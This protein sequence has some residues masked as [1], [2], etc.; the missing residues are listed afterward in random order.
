MY[1][2]YQCTNKALGSVITTFLLVHHRGTPPYIVVY[3]N[4]LVHLSTHYGTPLVHHYVYHK[5]MALGGMVTV[6]LCLKK[7]LVH[8]YTQKYNFFE[9]YIYQTNTNH[10]INLSG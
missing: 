3:Q 7:C 6:V 2:V 8:R 5:N 10:R 9:N 4:I 1:Q